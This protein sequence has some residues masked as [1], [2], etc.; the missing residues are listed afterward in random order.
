MLVWVLLSLTSVRENASMTSSLLLDKGDLRAA[1]PT[2][3]V[4][5]DVS[6]PEKSFS[7]KQ[8]L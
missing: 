4:L 2:G 7:Q 8:L 1:F 6:Y 5:I 3:L